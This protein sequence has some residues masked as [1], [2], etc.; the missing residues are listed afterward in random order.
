MSPFLGLWVLMSAHGHPWGLI[1]MG[2][3]LHKRSLVLMRAYGPMA[4]C[5]WLLLSS[6]LVLIAHWRQVH[7]N[8]W[9]LMGV[10][11]QS[12][13]LLSTHQHS[14]TLISSR[15]QQGVLMIAEEHLWPAMNTPELGAM[16]QWAL[17]RAQEQSWAWH[18]DHGHSS[19]LM[20][21]HGTIARYL[22]VL[23]RAQ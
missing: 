7:E 12:W 1:S 2:T 20:S 5:S 6:P 21:A 18:R 15:E 10:H 17:I 19:A 3:W 13:A 23:L 4:A 9:L 14:W 16:E 11:E 8:S 22:W